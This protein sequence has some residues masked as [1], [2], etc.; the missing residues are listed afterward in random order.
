MAKVIMSQCPN[1]RQAVGIG[2]NPDDPAFVPEQV[3][4]TVRVLYSG[5]CLIGQFAQTTSS[6][7]NDRP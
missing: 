4:V 5:P 1:R 7:I 3:R 2:L 6:H